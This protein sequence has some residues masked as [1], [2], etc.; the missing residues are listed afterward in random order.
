MAFFM[1]KAQKLIQF[2]KRP[3]SLNLHAKLNCRQRVCFQ[4]D[5]NSEMKLNSAYTF[6]YPMLSA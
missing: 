6:F 5:A 1:N 4:S 3:I 2:V